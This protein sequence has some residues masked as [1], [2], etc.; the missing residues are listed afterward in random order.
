MLNA[1]RGLLMG[2]LNL[3]AGV[4]CN[5][6]TVRSQKNRHSPYGNFYD[7]TPDLRLIW[8]PRQIATFFTP[9]ECPAPSPTT[10]PLA[11]MDLSWGLVLLAPPPQVG[12]N[13]SQPFTPR[14]M[15][16]NFSKK[17]AGPSS[18]DPFRESLD[19]NELCGK[20]SGALCCNRLAFRP[21]I[22]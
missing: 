15:V 21:N 18:S 19:E 16:H 9:G 11:V 12:P 5:H 3:H 20:I 14:E 7:I 8:R 1:E 17:Q 13:R 4:G 2:E 22:G 6:G 10:P